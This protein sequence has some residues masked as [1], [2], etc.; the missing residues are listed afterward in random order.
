MIMLELHDIETGYG[1][2]QVL[3]GVSL[4]V[5]AGACVS[6]MGR[7]GM[8]KTTTVRA[9]MGQLPLSVGRISRFGKDHDDRPSFDIARAGIGLVPEGRQIFRTSRC[10]K[11]YKHSTVLLPARLEPSGILSGCWRCFRVWLNVWNR[12]VIIC[13][14][15]N[16]KCWRL[17]GP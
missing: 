16:S 2:G 10:E 8:G 4:A 11:I 12:L 9:I 3:F 7:N 17:D 15:V 1:A 6:L 5:T 13:L 14:V